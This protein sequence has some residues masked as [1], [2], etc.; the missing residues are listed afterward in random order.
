MKY[1]GEEKVELRFRYVEYLRCD[2][3]N[4]KINIDERYYEVTE[5]QN[6]E[7]SHSYYEKHICKN[8]L[9]SYLEDKTF[10]DEDEVTIQKTKLYKNPVNVMEGYEPYCLANEDKG[11]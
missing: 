7:Y 2:C 9:K 8:C 10:Y 11:E 4:K 3:C 5:T 1:L 6:D